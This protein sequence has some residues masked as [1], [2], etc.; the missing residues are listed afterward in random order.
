MSQ[1]TAQQRRMTPRLWVASLAL[2][3]GAISWRGALAA[4]APPPTPPTPETLQSM[5]LRPT[6]GVHFTVWSDAQPVVVRDVLKVLDQVAEMVSIEAARQGWPMESEP[7][8][9][10]VL[11]FETEPGFEA[12]RHAIVGETDVPTGF[13]SPAHQCSF[14]FDERNSRQAIANA[15]EIAAAREK[16]NELVREANLARKAGAIPRADR[17]LGEARTKE[18]VVGAELARLNTEAVERL[19]QVVTHEGAHQLLFERGTQSPQ[20]HYP[21]W[22]SE[23]L[24][25]CFEAPGIGEPFGPRQRSAFRRG[26]W[27]QLILE[28]RPEQLAS[29][30]SRTS[31]PGY[32]KE[33]TRFYNQSAALVAWLLEHRRTEFAEYLEWFRAEGKG[34]RLTPQDQ[35]EVFE[36]FFGPVA[37]LER[38]WQRHELNQVSGAAATRWGRDLA[39][40]QAHDPRQAIRAAATEAATPPAD[41]PVPPPVDAPA[42]PTTEPATAPPA[43]PEPPTTPPA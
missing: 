16:L 43:A 42:E 7:G 33:L 10:L 29:L 30:V 32:G 19:N 1:R 15:R 8:R 24:A 36:Q 17:I 4:V 6:E 12:G 9:H 23:G 40:S 3:G 25:I 41:A 26:E 14:F 21:K 28:D 13:Y 31:Q 39:A 11:F 34:R 5:G 20:A 35:L 22:A 38:S 2:V 27:K 18:R 37:S